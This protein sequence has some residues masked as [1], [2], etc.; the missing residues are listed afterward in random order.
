MQIIESA[1]CTLSS[2]HIS[3]PWQEVFMLNR[4][5][6]VQM[7]PTQSDDLSVCVCMS[8][9]TLRESV[10]AGVKGWDFRDC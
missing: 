8:M 6:T 2:L 3:C 9:S 1:T 4:R 5:G 10:A 7:S